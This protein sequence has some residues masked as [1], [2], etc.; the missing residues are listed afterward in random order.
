[1][2]IRAGE[3]QSDCKSIENENEKAASQVSA[4]SHIF[5]LPR[6]R[7]EAEGGTEERRGGPKKDWSRARREW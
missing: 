2:V 6:A 4:D 1:M 3:N 5:L 7:N